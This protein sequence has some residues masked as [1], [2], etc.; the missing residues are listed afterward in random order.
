MHIAEGRVIAVSALSERLQRAR[1]EMGQ[2]SLNEL[3]K[4]AE[5]RGVRIDRS[6]VGKF[7]NGTHAP[8]PKET[9]LAAL[10]EL[11]AVPVTDL[12]ELAGRPPGELGP[13]VPTPESASLT[14]RQRNALDELIRS[15]VAEGANDAG[16]AD[17]EK[18]ATVRRLPTADEVR[19]Q[20][21]RTMQERTSYVEEAAYRPDEDPQK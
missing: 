3:M 8:R 12:R 7:L 9:S 10:A 6:Q 20:R 2:P 21:A 14:D 18:S 5:K 1:D 15:F 19:K 11:F 4:L 17:A 13:Y 16:D